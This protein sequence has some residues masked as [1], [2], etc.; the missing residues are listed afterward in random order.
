MNDVAIIGLG[1]MGSRM[2]ARL[3]DAGHR[4]RVT[5][6]DR[7]R[8]RALEEMGA[9]FVDSP[10][11]VARGSA[12]VISM[13]TDD[14]ASRAVWLDEARGALGGLGPGA[15]AVESST[16]TPA[17]ATALASSVEAHGATLV[18]A[19]VI[20]SR[21]QAEAGALIH[22]T[23]GPRAQVQRVQP[24][25]EAM[26]SAA[27]HVGDVGQAMTLKLAVNTLF[28]AQVA[29]WAEVIGVV[30]R[31][32]VEPEAAVDLLGRTPVASPALRGAAAAIVAQR[33]EPQFPIELVRKDLDYFVG[34]ATATGA[35]VPTASA[36]AELYGR[37]CIA[38]HGGDNVVG[39]ARM[40]G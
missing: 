38:G 21:P 31:A 23:G 13:V 15:V 20:G 24:F 11:E 33:F 26:G 19:P 17:W 32:G 9:T 27:H 16:L 7:A 30:G 39:V 22:L 3:L 34:Q 4:V 6:R 2:A 12:V 18:A 36:I 14:D 28:A 37:A 29:A 1:A 25:L 35:V 8:A 40:V 5:T 10:R